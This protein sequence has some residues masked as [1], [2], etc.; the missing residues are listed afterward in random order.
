M[1][2]MANNVHAIW[3]A[4][5]RTPSGNATWLGRDGVIGPCCRDGNISSSLIPTT[6]HPMASVLQ[7]E[8]KIRKCRR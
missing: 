2:N 4:I 7:V 3:L 6:P 8:L 5:A 1:N